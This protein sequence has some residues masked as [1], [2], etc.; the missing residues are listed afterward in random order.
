MNYIILNGVNSNTISGLIIQSL[1]PITKPLMRTEVEEIDGRDGDII[2]KLGYSAYDKEMTVGLYGDFD[3]DEVIAYF[4]SEGTAT[5]SNEPDKLYYYQINEQ[6]DF[7]RLVRYRTAT[8]TLHCQPFKYDAN[9][10]EIMGSGNSIEESGTGIVQIEGAQDNVSMNVWADFT[11]E[12]SGTG[13]PSPS[14]PRPFVGKTGINLYVTGRNVCDLPEDTELPLADAFRVDLGQIVSVAKIS[15]TLIC[16]NVTF[17]TM[18]TNTRFSMVSGGGATQTQLIRLFDMSAN[19][20][21]TGTFKHTFTLN[22]PFRYIDLYLGSQYANFTGGTISVQ[23]ELSDEAADF[24]TYQ[25]THYSVDWT[26][27]AGTLYGGSWNVQE[28]KIYK[29]YEKVTLDN[30]AS[31]VPNGATANASTF[32]W[33]P[34]RYVG[35]NNILFSTLKISSNDEANT[36]EDLGN[37]TILLR[38]PSS[39]AQTEAAARTWLSSNPVD[40]AYRLFAPY[41][42]Y[43]VT[44]IDTKSVGG[45]TNVFAGDPSTYLMVQAYDEYSVEVVNAGNTFAKP[46]ITIQA[47]GSVSIYV[48]NAQIF[49]IS[50]NGHSLITIDAAAMNAYDPDTGVLMN[51][52]VVGDYS[53]FVFKAGTN[54]L[55]IS[56]NVSDIYVSRYSRWI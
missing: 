17:T 26:S 3:I 20:P 28:G 42:N 19:T 56:G 30:T 31:L 6:I 29:H 22:T 53:A 44:A 4:D 32:I 1:P 52:S 48:N 46:T 18:G 41:T 11:P 12:Q 43:D 23:I 13:D 7:E 14:N 50:M 15:Y 24:E 34:T 37:R 36:A 10:V 49:Q 21:N 33:T 45:I 27:V 39:V 35:N 40:A 5:F 54:T 51:R 2:T 25:G 38:L 16:D 55:G 9:E 47:I 8:V